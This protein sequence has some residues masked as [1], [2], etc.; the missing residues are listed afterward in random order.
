[1][2]SPARVIELNVDTLAD[3][4]RVAAE[5]WHDA[6]RKDYA[7]RIAEAERELI[8]AGDR[9]S[10][11][12]DWLA[13]LMREWLLIL[14]RDAGGGLRRAAIQFAHERP[15]PTAAAAVISPIKGS[16]QPAPD[17]APATLIPELGDEEDGGDPFHDFELFAVGRAGPALQR[18]GCLPALGTTAIRKAARRRGTLRVYETA[19]RWL[20]RGRRG[21]HVVDW[22]APFLIDDLRAC[23]AIVCDSPA[24]AA[25]LHR[26]L[27]RQPRRLSRLMIAREGAP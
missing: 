25:A 6:A 14:H 1:M 26:R 2:M 12:K 16:W 9:N 13:A 15:L 24:H 7:T 8:A 11:V 4:A 18:S 3:L 17:G 27:R 5:S 21:A 10:C 19:Q 23:G 22:S 20:A